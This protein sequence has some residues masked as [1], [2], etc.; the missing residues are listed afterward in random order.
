MKCGGDE[1]NS[2]EVALEMM[3][4]VTLGDPAVFWYFF[5]VDE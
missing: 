3:D 5:F 2:H 4:S 1:I